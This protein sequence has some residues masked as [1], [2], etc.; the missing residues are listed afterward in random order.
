MVPLTAVGKALPVSCAKPLTSMTLVSWDGSSSATSVQVEYEP[1][2][3]DT[4]R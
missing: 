3:C 2:A 1:G 4:A